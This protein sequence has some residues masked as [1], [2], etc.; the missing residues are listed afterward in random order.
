LAGSEP[1]AADAAAGEAASETA[2]GAVIIGNAGSTAIHSRKLDLQALQDAG[3]GDGA[4]PAAAAEQRVWA[5]GAPHHH[6]RGAV[7]RLEIAR[8]W[9][10][11]D[12]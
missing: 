8:R 4:D 11:E 1:A 9:P 10:I 2:E 5:E 6:F 12:D 3:Y 7:V